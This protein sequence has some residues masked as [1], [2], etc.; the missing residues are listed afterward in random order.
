[1]PER[2]IA[3]AIGAQFATKI[4]PTDKIIELI[5]KIDVPCVLLGGPTDAERA[6]EICE[7]TFGKQLINLVGQISLLES[8]GV[9]QKAVLV[10]THDT[11]LMHFASAFKVP[12][13][14][15]WGNTVP[16]LGMYPYMNSD[17]YS[18]HQV[19]ELSCRPCSKIGFER[20]PKGHFSCMNKQDLSAIAM[21]IISRWK[22][23]I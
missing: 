5:N 16:E 2:F 14:S 9:L 1:M 20:C 6:E 7:K 19:V 23:T 3:F 13:V 10:I 21:D 22:K 12:T 8:A 11:G 18:I 17:Q 15:I 4:L